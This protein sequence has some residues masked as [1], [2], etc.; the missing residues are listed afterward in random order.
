MPVTIVIGSQWGDEGKGKI[1]DLLSPQFDF[2]ARYQGGANAGH[3]IAWGDQKFVLHLVPSGIFNEGVECIVGNGVVVDPMSLLEEIELVEKIGYQVEGRLH[4][5]RRAH[6]IFP[7]HQSRDASREKSSGSSK[8]GTTKKGIGPAYVDKHMRSGLRMHD[9]VDQDKLVRKLRP[10]LESNNEFLKWKFGHE[11]VD[12]GSVLDEYVAIGKRL[13]SY[14]ADTI[15]M[16]HS[17]LDDGKNVLA[18]GAQ[19]ALLDIDFGTYP[20]VTSSHPTSGGSCVGLG[21]PPSSIER[22]IGIT[23]AYLTRVGEGPFPTELHDELGEKI[24][25]EGAEFGAT[26]GRPRRCGWIDIPALKYSAKL[27]GITELSI[28]KLDVLS[29]LD[30]IGVATSYDGDPRGAFPACC[31]DLA[32][33][34]PDYTMLKGWTNDITSAEEMNDLPQAAHDYLDFVQKESGVK[35]SMV[36]VGPKRSQTLMVDAS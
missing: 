36:S 18:E 20:Y 34:N 12:V 26:T 24:R 22:V 11:P 13:K 6:V 8:I 27:S 19:G 4:I 10:L 9:L 14:T 30:Q 1:V 17:A 23:K 16:L 32:V 2:V 33:V 28:T 7:F 31:D 21:I 29:G 35:I 15:H 25:A 5:S 3:T